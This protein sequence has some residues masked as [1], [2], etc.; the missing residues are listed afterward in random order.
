MSSTET[1]TVICPECGGEV[2]DVARGHKLHK[3]WNDH[4]GVGGAGSLAFDTPA[5]PIGADRLGDAMDFEHVIM[6][7]DGKAYDVR[8]TPYAPECYWEGFANG[9]H[10]EAGTGWELMDGYSGQHGYSGP[11]MHASEY[12]GG[13]MVDDILATDGYYAAVV[14]DVLDD[15]DDEPAGWAVARRDL[16]D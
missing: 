16:D 2:W 3:C 9:A 7:R 1:H 11:I 6:V 14:C 4:P 8:R 13:R 5:V 12:I 15:E 10:I